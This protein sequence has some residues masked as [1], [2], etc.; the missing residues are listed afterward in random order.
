MVD[1]N[2]ERSTNCIDAFIAGMQII[3]EEEFTKEDKIDFIDLFPEYS[4]ILDEIY[5]FLNGKIILTQQQDEDEDESIT[6]ETSVHNSRKGCTYNRMTKLDA[7]NI[8]KYI[9]EKCRG[10]ADMGMVV[11]DVYDYINGKFNKPSIRDIV[12]GRTWATISQNYFKI[13]KGKIKTV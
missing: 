12:H 11:N 7:E 1:V 6:P 5:N 13:E 9:S 10:R 3:E 4:T 8:C 2:I